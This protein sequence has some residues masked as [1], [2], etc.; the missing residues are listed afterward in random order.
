MVV[1]FIS[2]F[3]FWVCKMLIELRPHFLL[4]FAEHLGVLVLAVAVLLLA[5]RDALTDGSL[6]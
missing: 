1:D 2:S 5:N 6:V 4:G 3:A